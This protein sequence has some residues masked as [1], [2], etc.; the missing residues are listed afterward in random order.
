MTDEF[1]DANDPLE[2]PGDELELGDE[3]V[4][5]IVVGAC[6]RAEEADRP[7]AYRLQ[8]RVRR[9]LTQHADT[10]QIR[11]EPIVCSDVWYLNSEELQ[12]R[13]TIS[14]GGPG[15]N[16]L[17]AYFAQ[18]LEEEP[19]EETHVLIQIDPEFTDLRAAIWGWDHELTS[20]GVE[21][22]CKQYL[23]Q[24]LR[25]VATQVEPREE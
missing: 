6:L 25:A 15:V 5:M 1:D 14:I 21:V 11:I 17:S 8:R 20:K 13:P 23:D 3:P 2:E 18:Q 12:Q 10:L 9:W 7:L 4:V 22:F 24:F 16:A 19:G